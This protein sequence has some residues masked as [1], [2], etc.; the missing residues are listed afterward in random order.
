MPVQIC[1]KSQS[2]IAI[3]SIERIPSGIVSKVSS[4]FKHNLTCAVAQTPYWGFK[5]RRYVKNDNICQDTS[6]IND[7]L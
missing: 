6:I 5:N 1:T 7:F 3:Y 2:A 4:V